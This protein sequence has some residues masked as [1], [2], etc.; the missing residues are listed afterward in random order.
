MAA[1]PAPRAAALIALDWGTTSLRA[2]L[3]GPGAEVLERRAGPF[4]LL[5]ARDRAFL[6]AYEAITGDW[7]GAHPGVAALACGM[8]GSAQGWREAPYVTAP[9]DAADVAGALVDAPVEGLRIVPG[10]AQRSAHPDVM[11]G[12]ETQVIGALA[13][14]PELAG[15]SLIL[16]PGTHAKWVRVLAGRIDRFTTYLT[17]ELYS[18][19]REHST[20]GRLAE[21]RPEAS[22]S[23]RS[24]AFTEGVRRARD[25]ETTGGLAPLL[26]GVRA[27]A[28]VGD[29]PPG[30]SVDYLSGLLLGDEIRSGLAVAGPPDA[31]AG[32]PT[33]CARYADALA[34]FGLEGVPVLGDPAPLGLWTI[35]EYAF[36]E[37]QRRRG[38]SRN[39]V[40]ARVE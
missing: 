17:G 28:L 15:R 22:G 29:L 3:L 40:S 16:L 37:A 11:R 2:Y 18:L 12:E 7:R 19:L 9:A 39:P 33:L 36:H 27:R 35:A 5:Q 8:I 20:L 25:A 21:E 31:L 34:L 24:A 38:E 14:H 4:G 13:R 23:E 30:A 1:A 6:A 32:D 26:F 10:V